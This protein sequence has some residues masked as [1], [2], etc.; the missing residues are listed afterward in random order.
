MSGQVLEVNVTAG[1][2][3]EAGQ[4]LMVMEAMKMEHSIRAAEDGV[5][6]Q[7]FYGT[8]DQVFEGA[9]LIALQGEE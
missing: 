2:Q 5:V 8:G 3:V 1:D 4:V 6:K 7:V 9:E